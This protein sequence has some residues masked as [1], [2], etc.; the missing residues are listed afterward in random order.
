MKLYPLFADLSR[1]AVLVVGGGAVAERKVAALLGAQ[2]QVTVNAPVLT[3]QLQ[4]WAAAG[5]IAHRGDAFQEAWLERV[6]LVVAATSDAEL[7]RL[8]ATLAGLRRIF[9][10]VVDDAVLSSFHVPALVDRAPLTIAISSGGAA[11]MLSRLLRERLETLL[12]PSLGALGLLAARLRRRIRLRHPE[13]ATR[14]RFYENLFAGPVADLL[15][16][17]RPE[18]ARQA[19]EQALAAAPAVPAGS[20]LLVGAGPG[21]PGLLTLRAL[22]ALNEADVI[23]HDHLV[24]AEVLALARR[25]AERIEVGKQA[26]HHHTT[27]DGIHALLL[28]HARA[29]RRVVRLKGGDPFVFGRGGEELEFLRAHG[30]PYEVVPGITAAV[31]CAAHAGVP[32][33]HRDHAQSVRFVTAHCQSS[34]DSLDWAALAQERQTLAVYMGVAELTTLQA[35]LLKHG[36]A[37]STPFALVENGS[38]PQQRVVTGSLANMVERAAFHAVRSPALLILGEVASLATS[39]AW[40]G[41]PPLGAAVPA[42]RPARAATTDVLAAV[43]RT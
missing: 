43:H 14:R 40:F 33:T 19:A 10:N 23:L 9:V 1:R 3:P 2:A 37:P 15:R 39:L 8:I 12:D 35:R 26:G 27:Q 13:P 29:G 42:I 25:D 24:S 4:R 16:Q 36:R 6:W 22:R 28:E 34:R 5:R 11:P 21:D 20:V 17:G 18:D 7:N 32:L 41:A 30:I 38:L 31:A